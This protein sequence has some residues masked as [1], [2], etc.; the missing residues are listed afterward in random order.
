MKR[1]CMVCALAA[2][3]VIGG[4]SARMEPETGGQTS[5]TAADFQ[6]AI[7]QP[8][9][10]FVDFFATWCGPCRAMKPVVEQAEKDYA[11]KIKFLAIDVDRNGPLAQEYKVSS[12]PAFYVFKDGKPVDGRVGAMPAEELKKWLDGFVAAGG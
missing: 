9:L 10:V 8:G 6:A 7:G 2:A 11:G 5:A 12:I 4:C 1:I 3:L